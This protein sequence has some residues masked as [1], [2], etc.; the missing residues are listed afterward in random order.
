MI[1]E[2]R[3]EGKKGEERKVSIKGEHAASGGAL[4]NRVALQGAQQ[5]AD[6]ASKQAE[7]ADIGGA[8]KGQGVSSGS[9]QLSGD[10][11]TPRAREKRRAAGGR[12]K[13]S[14]PAGQKLGGAFGKLGSGGGGCGC[15]GVLLRRSFK[16]CRLRM[17]GWV[18][19]AARC[20]MQGMMCRCLGGPHPNGLALGTCRAA[21][22]GG[23][24]RKNMRIPMAERK[25]EE[26]AA[27]TGG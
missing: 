17:D 25:I 26:G 12:L 8:Q 22:A 24:R 27:E 16:N 2:G 23:Q 19:G 3:N 13:I 15:G 9:K 18:D 5:P 11:Q 4:G 6:G 1:K 10:W 20:P 7:Q 21:A 14:G